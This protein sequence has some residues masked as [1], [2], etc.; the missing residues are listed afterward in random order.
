MLCGRVRRKGTLN[1]R[2][3]T[4]EYYLRNARPL[5]GNRSEDELR[6]S[7]FD[8]KQFLEEK[9][10]GGIFSL[11]DR[12][13]ETT[14]RMMDGE[15]A[16]RQEKALDW[17]E[18]TLRL[19][20]ELF[21]CSYL[22][23][24]DAKDHVVTNA[25]CWPAIIRTD[26]VALR[27]VM[28]RGLAEN[29]YHLNGSTQ[30]FPLTWGFLMNHPNE[31]RRYFSDRKFSDNLH[32]EVSL[33]V[34]DNQLSWPERI[35]LA[36]WLRAMLFAR[37]N[38]GIQLSYTDG[39]PDTEIQFWA[40]QRSLSK[41]QD[42]KQLVE[43]LRLQT[44]IRF[45]RLDGR[46]ECLDYAITELSPEEMRSP[47]RFLSGERSFLYHCFRQCYTKAFSQREQDLFYLYLLLKAKFRNELIQNNDRYG[48]RN[49]ADYQDRKNEIWEYWHGYWMEAGRLA[50]ATVK[51]GNVQSLEMRIIPG[52]S[53]AELMGK[54]ELP[55]QFIQHDPAKWQEGKSERLKRA[56]GDPRYFYVIHFPKSP[57]EPVERGE[58]DLPRLRQ[59]KLR[60]KV[61]R[62]A[63]V[64]AESMDRNEY[65][66]SRIRGIDA[67]SHEIGCRPEVFAQAFR[68]L[69]GNR[70]HY[71]YRGEPVGR[72]FALRGTYHAGE[73]FL[74][75]TDGLRAVDE[76]V[77]F[78]DLERGERIGHGLALGVDPHDYYKL[79]GYVVRMPAQDLLDNLVWL[80]QRGR[81]WGVH[82]PSEL[83]VSL[84]ERAKTLLKQIY[85]QAGS[86]TQIGDYFCGWMLRGDDPK[87]YYGALACDFD[88]SKERP[89]FETYDCFGL[90][91]HV[92]GNIDIAACRAN[93]RATK[94]NYYY[95][96]G[97]RER[98][99]GQRV[100][101]FEITKEY[102]ELIGRMQACMLEKLMGKGIAIEC[103]PSSNYLI[104]TF[105]D[106][107]KHPIFR[108][109][110]YGLQLPEHPEKHTQLR[111]S[112]NTDDQGVFDCALENEYALLF[113]AL[114]TRVD[115]NGRREV[116]DDEALEY[117][118]HIRVMGLSSA[119]P[120]V[121]GVSGEDKALD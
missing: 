81:E 78:L 111:V 31:A 112:V 5:D 57:L 20:Q 41:R 91:D 80:A 95:Q 21:T 92:W 58:G 18:M 77:C 106:Y 105:R 88:I 83:W 70:P 97:L 89:S 74:D 118:D 72:S 114:T 71:N 113:A 28:R 24:Q 50:S 15:L 37:S 84:T 90:N 42:V 94:L 87:R 60:K 8:L 25:F 110:N 121:G 107:S 16:F 44:G 101:S 68:Y 65:L 66:R 117:L 61:R 17:R 35:Y 85:P 46:K 2:M 69:R 120:P 56:K 108:F 93:P 54:I 6:Q 62:F 10:S 104:G 7:Y 9:P 109:N 33:G 119:F 55:D 30:S 23:H 3:I 75:L 19:G 47:L 67:A 13:T 99:Q 103:N 39:A 40:F 22:A 38:S 49:F 48:F 36:A 43:R 11:L 73:D 102:A 53:Y 29:H 51:T 96:Y 76:A 12:Y 79:K 4:E 32:G 1:T 45:A 86:D 59:E 27:E 82:I 26:S 115:H 100:V 64:I 14:L 63:K 98:R 116:S 34:N 52:K